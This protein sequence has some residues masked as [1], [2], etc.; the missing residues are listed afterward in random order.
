[1]YPLLR[2]LKV[3]VAVLLC[4]FILSVGSAQNI[5]IRHFSMA[6]GLA[7]DICYQATQTSDGFLWIGTDAGL[8]RFDG[9]YFKNYDIQEGLSSPY[10]IYPSEGQGGV[11]WLGTHKKGLNYLRQGEIHQLSISERRIT[12]PIVISLEEGAEVVFSDKGTTCTICDDLIKARECRH[13][14]FYLKNTDVQ[15]L[16]SHTSQVQPGEKPIKIRHV[17]PFKKV[18]F[19]VTEAGIF[20]MKREGTD[21][22]IEPYYLDQDV[23]RMAPLEGGGFYFIKGD[24]IFFMDPQKQLRSLPVQFSK[25]LILIPFGEYLVVGG[26][27]K[28]NKLKLFDLKDGRLIRDLAQEMG[29]ETEISSAILDRDQNLWI[30]TNGSGLFCLSFSPFQNFSLESGLD[31][32]N[33][34]F[35]EQTTDGTI[36]MG[37][38]NGIFTYEED[39]IR[40]FPVP[41]SSN[42]NRSNVQQMVAIEGNRLFFRVLGMPVTKIQDRE[43]VS[44]ELHRS[45]AKDFFPSDD[46]EEFYFYQRPIIYRTRDCINTE[47]VADLSILQEKYDVEL[48]AN[49]LIRPID[50]QGNIWWDHSDS[51]FYIRKDSIFVFDKHR[52][53]PSAFLNKMVLGPQ[54]RWW[55]GS[56]DGAFFL[57]QRANGNFEVSPILVEGNVKDIVFDERGVTW[58]GTE[59]GLVRYNPAG[60]QLNKFSNESGLAGN[61]VHDLLLTQNGVLWIA[62][63]AGVSRLDVDDLSWKNNTNRVLLEEYYLN[64]ELRQGALPAVIPFR[65]SIRFVFTSLHLPYTQHIQLE[66]RIRDS[67]PWTSTDSRS[68]FLSELLPE[69]YR[70]Q[71]RARSSD[72]DWSDPLELPFEITPPWWQLWWVRILGVTLF[73]GLM[74]GIFQFRMRRLRE[75]DA[76]EQKLLELE[77]NALQ[78]QM[79]P[80][81]LF[82]ALNAIQYFIFKKDQLTANHYISRFSR[83]MRLFLESSNSSVISLE[84]EVELLELYI[85][86]EQLRLKHKFDYVIEVKSPLTASGIHIYATFLQPFVENAINHGLRH[87]KEKGH[88]H[89]CFEEH[90]KGI[91]CLIE[92]DGIGRRQAKELADRA[93]K[94]YQSRGMQLI[95]DRVEVIEQLNERK[96][97]IQVLDLLDDQDQS[98]GTRVEI[99]LPNPG[100]MQTK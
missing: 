48:G 46:K 20:K 17:V 98:A 88:L 25:P 24:Q 67:D 37:G 40:P 43:V 81:F 49:M 50:R 82:N 9:K 3:S 74:W 92:D 36:W 7:H 53:F 2:K 42:L 54:G 38:N 85:E 87:K 28:R 14:Q 51:L 52:D 70:L 16:E 33:V 68:L 80:H 47:E 65:T 60:G 22:L 26:G 73:A 8:S 63:N 15:L 100:I 79:N 83:L 18:I 56:V 29:F 35:L 91:R 95:A 27:P 58:L 45:F 11:I 64:N 19:L 96:I 97:E 94:S 55:L 76:L 4:L 78:S 5:N 32:T 99:V 84:D 71:V 6:D 41:K 89:I 34:L 59:K 21:W 13:Y 72:S 57:E 69:K 86:L 30:T 75:K 12:D 39:V 44:C 31:N 93:N 1:M 23:T 61:R 66:W 62:T 77:L 10:V 90:P